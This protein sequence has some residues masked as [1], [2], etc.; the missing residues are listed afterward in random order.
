MKTCR[1]MHC[2]LRESLI[3]VLDVGVVVVHAMF[4]DLTG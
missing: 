2:L 4:T 1:A 3:F